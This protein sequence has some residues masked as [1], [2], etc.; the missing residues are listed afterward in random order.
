MA[1]DTKA[2]LESLAQAAGATQ[3]ELAVALKVFGSE[4]VTKKLGEDLMLRPE[5]SRRMD[6]LTK[7]EKSYET[8]YQDV[9][10]TT[11]EN[12]K[13]VAEYESLVKQYQQQYGEIEGGTRMIAS[14]TFDEKKI[15]EEYDNRLKQLESNTLGLFKTGLKIATK[16]LKE[17]D[18]VLDTDA[19][20]KFAV[21]NNLSLE[22]AYD[23]FVSPRVQE[24]QSKEWEEKL[25]LAR[26]EGAKDALSKHHLPLDTKPSTPHP[27]FDRAK[28]DTPPDSRSLRNEFSA[29]FHEAA[30]KA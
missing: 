9:L 7:K 19:L 21:E 23:K 27:F 26:E 14:P 3:E 18:E 22:A 10:K 13:T 30:A 5:F 12:K 2:Y 8:W 1:V 29:A 24:K 16:H 20:A 25:R 17:F 15:R 6:E 11:E 4:A 28:V